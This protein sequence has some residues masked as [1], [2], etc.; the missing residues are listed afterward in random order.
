MYAHVLTGLCPSRMKPLAVICLWC[1]SS[2]KGG[3][4]VSSH[5]YVCSCSALDTRSE[6]TVQ[7]ALDNIMQGRTTVVV[8]HRLSTV[9]GADTIAGQQPPPPLPP[10]PIILGTMLLSRL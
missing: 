2:L 7:K 9:A 6:A 5:A 10:H 3:L 1:F 4:R 8:A